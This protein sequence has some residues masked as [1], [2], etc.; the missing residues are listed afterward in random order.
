MIIIYGLYNLWN[1]IIN[2][3]IYI[4]SFTNNLSATNNPNFTLS[5]LIIFLNYKKE[6]KQRYF[7]RETIP[8][9]TP[10]FKFK[11]MHEYIL[12]LEDEKIDLYKFAATDILNQYIT[13]LQ[14]T[15]SGGKNKNKYKNTKNKITFIYKKKEYTRVIY[16]CERK[17]YV[18]INKTFMLL[19]KLK[20]V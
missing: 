18:K 8:T 6:I 14:L 4:N 7:F 11:L 16:I 15:M 13:I 5:Q 2:V 9:Y 20:K 12:T 10:S 17:K 1:T 19:S 3:A